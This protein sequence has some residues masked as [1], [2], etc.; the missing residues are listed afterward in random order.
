M[1][2]AINMTGMVFGA[3]TVLCE[4]GRSGDGKIK[5][6]VK[7]GCG[8]A[9]SATGV[10]IRSG[11]VRSCPDCSKERVRSASTTHGKSQSDEYR[12]WTHIKSRC[13]NSN[14]PEFVNY[15]GRG[16]SICDR[17]R[18]SFE[19][20]LSDMGPR[21][22]KRH[23]IDRIDTNGNYEPDNCRWATN[24]VQANNRRA[25]RLIEIEG[26]T[27]TMAQWADGSGLRH[28]TL[29]K[30]LKKGVSGKTLLAASAAPEKYTFRGIT[31]SIPE[32]SRITGIK[33]A[34]LYWRIK[35]Q[36]WALD[37]ALTEGATKCT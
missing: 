33:K 37:K 25:N 8:E 14:V 34:T 30:R 32:W 4:N 2:S 7:C 22:S 18:K 36:S 23:S 13:L 29:L 31:A 3:L 1:G 10:R 15:G 21:P 12:I 28:E 11:E 6:L 17:W 27:K 16:I 26:T 35:N 9:F 5:W 24:K 20:F 19:N